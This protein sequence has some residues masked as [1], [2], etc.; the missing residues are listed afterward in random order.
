MLTEKN[1]SANPRPARPEVVEDIKRI[2]ADFTPE[3]AGEIKEEHALIADLGWDSLDMV[4]MSMQVEELY[5]IP[6]PDEMVD[7]IKTV[8]DVVEAVLRLFEQKAD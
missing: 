7:D 3:M 6:V 8:G 5:D 1:L 2:V 4:E